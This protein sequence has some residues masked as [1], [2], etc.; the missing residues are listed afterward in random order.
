MFFKLDLIR[1]GIVLCDSASVNAL[2][3]FVFSRRVS[4]SLLFLL[5]SH[6]S[7]LSMP[8][9]HLTSLF[10]PM[11]RPSA[12]LGIKSLF[13]NSHTA[14]PST[15]LDRAPAPSNPTTSRI[16]PTPSSPHLDSHGSSGSDMRRKI[17]LVARAKK[18]RPLSN[19]PLHRELPSS[20]IVVPHK[21]TLFQKP[22]G[23]QSLLR[24]AP[25]TLESPHKTPQKN[26]LASSDL[27]AA[28]SRVF[29]RSSFAS[30]RPSPSSKSTTEDPFAV[31]DP[32]VDR[33]KPYESPLWLSSG[34]ESSF[35]GT[36]YSVSAESIHLF[37]P[38]AP[39][40]EGSHSSDLVPVL[41]PCIT[42]DFVRRPSSPSFDCSLS[43]LALPPS[44]SCISSPS[45]TRSVIEI[46]S[47]RSVIEVPI[48]SEPVAHTIFD[49]NFDY[50]A[51][52]VRPP[53]VVRRPAR[54]GRFVDVRRTATHTP[55]TLPQP[56]LDTSLSTPPVLGEDLT[57][58]LP[59]IS[60]SISDSSHLPSPVIETDAAPST[61]VTC[62]ISIPG[63]WPVESGEPSPV[64]PPTTSRSWFRSLITPAV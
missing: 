45:L 18:V 46:S 36:E 62:G 57:H 2:Y 56:S 30:A 61:I 37:S 41:S 27:L 20:G 49:P 13:S 9:T 1:S 25:K 42:F 4:S 31:H 7:P 34:S 17:R 55:S 10:S 51:A 5:S 8:S 38:E 19:T 22:S 28:S 14:T 40:V 50:I 59:S 26:L 64:P 32:F 63:S 33:N 47:T 44:V 12:V 16:H 48:S 52:M 60:I 54:Y 39:S 35:S 11:R 53:P 6:N 21:H 29:S 3:I 43:S 23:T 24:R 58:L 15:F